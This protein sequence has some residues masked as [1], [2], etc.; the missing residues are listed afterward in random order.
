MPFFFL[1]TNIY[2]VYKYSLGL[3]AGVVEI[4]AGVLER[5]FD[6]SAIGDKGDGRLNPPPIGVDE[7]EELKK[8]KFKRSRFWLGRDSL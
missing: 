8:S 6:M 3:E 7:V 4:E 5:L 1:F 2:I